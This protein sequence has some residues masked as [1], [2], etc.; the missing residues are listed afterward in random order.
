MK[1]LEFKEHT[2]TYKD[3]DGDEHTTTVRAATVEKGHL[4][5][6]V[7]DDDGNLNRVARRFSVDTIGGRVPVQE[8]DVVVERDRPGLYDV[9]TADQWKGNGY[10]LPKSDSEPAAPTAPARPT[11]GPPAKAPGK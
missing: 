1:E 10:E 7:E 11:T 3:D 5:R 6:L 8:G 9:L 2:H 4:S